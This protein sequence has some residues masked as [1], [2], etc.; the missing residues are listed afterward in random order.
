MYVIKKA[1]SPIK[2][3]HLFKQAFKHKNAG[4]FPHL[5]VWKTGYTEFLI[6]I[7]MLDNSLSY[8]H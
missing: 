1:F 8:G 2:F 4:I 5:Y 6:D 3:K 7:S